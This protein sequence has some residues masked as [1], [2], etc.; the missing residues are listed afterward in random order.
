M[1]T[2]SITKRL[3]GWLGFAAL[4]VLL[5]PF[6]RVEAQERVLNLLCWVGYEEP[7]MINVFE[8]KYGVK[9]NA[10][11]Y[12]GGDQMFTL[13]TQSQGLYDVVVVDPEFLPKLHAAGR[14]V[15]L[16][17]DDYDF[18][19]YFAPFKKFPF[20]EYDGDLFAVPIRFGSNGLVYNTNH[21]SKEDV[22][23]YKILWD[24]KVKGRVGIWDWYLPSMGVLSRAV[25]NRTPYDISE[26]QFAMLE[27]ATLDLRGQ[28]AAIHPSP[29]E[30][31]SALASEE[32]WIVPAGGEWVAAI[33]QAQGK[34]IDWTVPDEGG[35]MWSETLVIAKDAPHPDIAKLY[36]QWMQ[37]PEAQALL[38]QRDAY[39]SNVP[40]KKAYGILPDSHK[41]ILKI[42]NEKEAMAM[43][44]QI[45]VR[46]LPQ[47]QTES[48]WQDVW[49]RFKTAQ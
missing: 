1:T 5:L 38:T 42:H 24:P 6:G 10:K 37:T 33:L 16:N 36:I 15:K 27:K 46:T 18:S 28:V 9:V 17:R 25:G 47:Q 39:Y 30:M 35:I 11:T 32:T 29:P 26:D 3:F 2:A 12:V 7:S 21:L 13:F 22:K 14:I 49:E 44:D 45:S 34:P 4:V 41:D 31:L 23:S 19:D 20:T 40:N 43:L 8:D 48:A